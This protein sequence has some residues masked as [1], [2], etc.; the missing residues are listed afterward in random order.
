MQGPTVVGVKRLALWTGAAII[1]PLI[2]ASHGLAQTCTTTFNLG[3]DSSAGMPRCVAG[4]TQMYCSNRTVQVGAWIN[5][6]DIECS[7]DLCTDTSSTSNA[8]QTAWAKYPTYGTWKA[9]SEHRY[10]DDGEPWTPTAYRDAILDAGRDPQ[11]EC[12]AAGGHWADGVCEYDGNEPGSP[13]II[14]LARGAS[15][16]LTSAAEGVLFDIDGDGTAERVAWTEAD[17]DVAFLAFDRDGD[18]KI[19]SGRELFGNFTLPGVT[20]GFEALRQINKE[21]NG[22]VERGSVSSDDSLFSRLQLWTDRNHNG[23]SEASE[24]R[25]LGEVITDV[26]LGYQLMPR[27]DG[28]GNLFRLRGWVHIRTAPGRNEAK[29]Q[30][31]D[32]TRTRSI[33]DV[34]FVVQR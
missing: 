34:Y 5:G 2:L 32:R 1:A 25:P 28:H 12:E 10:H 15:Y 30:A 23:I 27:R 18:G 29:S 9:G 3:D 26:G 24:L 11:E 31:E 22:G 17:S 33:W 20:N 8:A 4:T 14:S 21:L 6:L 7:S 19:T 16:K 13:I